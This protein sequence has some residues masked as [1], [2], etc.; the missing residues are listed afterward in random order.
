M[1]EVLMINGSHRNDGN[2]AI[3]LSYIEKGAASQGGD[4]EHI[5][6]SDLRLEP[7]T[8]CLKCQRTGR[9]DKNDDIEI[10]LHAGLKAR[11]IV[12]GTPISNWFISS[13]MKL[14]L[15][16]EILYQKGVFENTGIVFALLMEPEQDKTLS[17]ML[18]ILMR[19][20]K[21][22]KMHYKGKI[23]ASGVLEIGDLDKLDDFK[24]EAIRLGQSL[25]AR[26]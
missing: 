1:V 6:L 4:I 8:Y 13:F 7:C 15:D 26:I 5:R 19:I 3:L 18:N 23:I 14:M 25:I 10:I 20:V 11:N 17:C 16:R 22:G 24:D 12:L 2:T 9:C 21:H